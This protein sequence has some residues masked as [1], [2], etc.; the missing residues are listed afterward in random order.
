VA[1]AR[2]DVRNAASPRCRT[3]VFHQF[4]RDIRAVYP[5]DRKAFVRRANECAAK[6]RY[7]ERLPE[8]SALFPWRG[9]HALTELRCA[10]P[11]DVGFRSAR[12]ELIGQGGGCGTDGRYG[13]VDGAVLNAGLLDESALD[14]G[15]P[16][17]A[18]VVQRPR[19]GGAGLALTQS[20][21]L[22]AVPRQHLVLGVDDELHDE[23]WLARLSRSRLETY[24][25]SAFLSRLPMSHQKMSH[26]NK[27]T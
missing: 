5:A 10:E 11:S 4:A 24:A 23:E 13:Y 19:H 6:A 8:Y 17:V 3:G 20:R 25:R 21:K 27:P 26:F 16:L 15:V 12:L 2:D 14:L 9:R 7:D 1:D 22:I 18:L